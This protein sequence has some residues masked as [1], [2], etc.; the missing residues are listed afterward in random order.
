MADD[1]KIMTEKRVATG[2]RRVKPN[3]MRGPDRRQ[4]KVTPGPLFAQKGNANPSPA[5][6]VYSGPNRRTQQALPPFITE[7]LPEGH[8][9]S[10]RRVSGRLGGRRHADFRDTPKLVDRDLRVAGTSGAGSAAER[11]NIVST[12][13]IRPKSGLPRAST[14][15][16]SSGLLR[17]AGR[18]GKIAAFA[19][20]GYAA[21]K[22][23]KDQ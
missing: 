5:S 17:K 21:A 16:S 3:A 14:I 8:P 7:R 23:W 2:P 18:L 9:V 22:A 15:G 11:G 12:P 10:G 13:V 4:P 20:G 19:L 1:K 6:N